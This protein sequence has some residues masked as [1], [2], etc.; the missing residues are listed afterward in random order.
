MK[1]S[2]I[3]KTYP[4]SDREVLQEAFDQELYKALRALDDLQ[5]ICKE[6]KEQCDR[7]PRIFDKIIDDLCSLR[8]TA[9]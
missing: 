4:K 2:E 7:N 1:F 5:R 6:N 8:P 3:I 9:I